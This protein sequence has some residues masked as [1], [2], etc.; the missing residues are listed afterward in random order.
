M[1]QVTFWHNVAICCSY[2]A[3]NL[4]C[5]PHT[6]LFYGV[7]FVLSTHTT[8]THVKVSINKRVVTSSAPQCHHVESPQH[9]SSI[10]YVDP[11]IQTNGLLMAASRC[12]S[13]SWQPPK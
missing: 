11:Q 7:E 13:P 9:I 12:I 5:D 2:R 8:G 4:L 10:F 3:A 6:T 1:K